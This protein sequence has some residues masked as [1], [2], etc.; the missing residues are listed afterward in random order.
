MTAPPDSILSHGE[1][2]V[3]GH[4]RQG[5]S[6]GEIADVRETS[7]AAIEQAI[8]R[9]RDKTSRALVT[10]VQSPYVEDC[11]R[12]LDAESRHEL[13]ETLRRADQ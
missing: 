6:A 1:Q 4:L 5:T 8:E 10:L 12:E 7:E 3:A 2:D 9:I 11:A 13:I